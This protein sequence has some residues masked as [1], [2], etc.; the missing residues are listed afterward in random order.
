VIVV[1]PLPPP[2]HGVTVSTS[3]ILA[4]Q[5]L[6][7]RFEIEH[8][9]TSDHR[10]GA[11]IG[12]W[13]LANALAALGAIGRLTPRLRGPKGVVY[14]P[15]SQST[16]GLLRDS[17]LVWTARLFGWKVAAHLRGSEFRAMFDRSPRLWRSWLRAMLRRLDS[18]AV[19]GE[20]LRTLFTGLVAPE[21]I[22]VVP[23][24]TPEPESFG[25]GADPRHVLFLS[26]L[27]RRKGVV[28]AVQAALLVLEREPTARFTFAGSWESPELERELRARSEAA[29]GAIS[30]RT[31]VRGREKD[32]LL[33]SATMLLFPP[34]QPEGHPRVVLEALAAGVPVVT[35]DRG[36]I[37]E[38]VV[39]GECGF[40]LPEPRP[41]EIADRVVT[42][43]RDRHLRA[44]FSRSARR[45]YLD[46]FTEERAG[47]TL[48]DWLADIA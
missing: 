36:A 10:S 45:R 20:S 7:E 21:R 23:N 15:L 44:R 11:N 37:A 9:D 1:G 31:A 24:G 25:S 12:T 16:P 43:L 42:L 35:T 39:D 5:R 47:A 48:V 40:V 30:F 38:T 34:V 2:V 13:D 26:N 19:M 22:R 46:R 17:L 3:L 6:R 18:V 14:L 32:R 27:K 8:L 28:E 29:D 41:E 4:N 33:S